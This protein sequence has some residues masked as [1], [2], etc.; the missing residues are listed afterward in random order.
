MLNYARIK[1]PK[2]SLYLETGQ[3]SEFTNKSGHGFDMLMQES[4]K[5]GFCKALKQEIEK[6]HSKEA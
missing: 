2:F 6:Y 5:Y 3:G 1:D 4:R